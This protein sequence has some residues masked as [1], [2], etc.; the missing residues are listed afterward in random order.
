MTGTDV[1]EDGELQIGS[2][3]LPAAGGSAAVAA[4]ENRSRG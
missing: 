4:W 2:V 1:P 3:L